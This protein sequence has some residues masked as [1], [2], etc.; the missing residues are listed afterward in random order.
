MRRG[1]EPESVY[2]ARLFWPTLYTTGLSRPVS[3][4]RC[5]IAP[6]HTD[7]GSPETRWPCRMPLGIPSSALLRSICPATRGG[8]AEGQ[9]TCWRRVYIQEDSVHVQHTT[10]STHTHTK[11]VHT[12]GQCTCTTHTQ[13]VYMLEESLQAVGQ[14]MYRRTVYMLEDCT[15]WRRVYVLRRVYI[16][17]D[18]VRVGGGCTCWR[19]AYMLEDSVHARGVCTY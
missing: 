15:C 4:K 9:C 12:G 14:C 1:I 8:V 11:C 10:C 13:S 17:E 18:S 3:I 5:Q 7:G 19:T 16:L 6:A 2:C